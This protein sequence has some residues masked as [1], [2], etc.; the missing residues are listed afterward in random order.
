MQDLEH[1]NPIAA[2]AYFG[3]LLG[4]LM[5]TRTPVL[6]C[7][8]LCGVLLYF[9]TARSRF[10]RPGGTLAFGAALFILSAIINPLVSHKG[11]TV[12]F[13]L[14]DN[15]ITLEALLYG[16]DTGLM[17][18]AS[19]L[20]FAVFS[21]I[22]T[23]D[24]CLYLLGKLS[25]R[26]ALLLSMS[27]RYIP[28]L[29]R[30][31]SEIRGARRAMGLEYDDN[32]V[33]SIKSGTKTFSALVSWSLENGIVTADSM[34]ARGFGIGRRTHFAIYKFRRADAAFTVLIA[35][36]AAGTIIPAA[37]GALS[38]DFYPTLSLA[39]SSA[40]SLA[41]YICYAALSLLAPM[42]NVIKESNE[43][44]CLSRI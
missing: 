25:P 16:A 39:P 9:L 20:W 17:L 35:V 34:D 23:A 4:I 10:R 13:L 2:F 27:L 19:F 44:C 38:I 36:L 5:F 18:C 6:L 7:E 12:L 29:R 42:L 15:R 26:L 28:L 30:R 21:S 1:L 24:R 43:R 40:A 8:A 41:A 31:A 14:N 3:A 22:M 11:N 33:D 37:L 32:I